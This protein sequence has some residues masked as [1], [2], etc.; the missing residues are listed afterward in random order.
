MQITEQNAGKDVFSKL[1]G[2]NNKKGFFGFQDKS[3]LL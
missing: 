1:S 3:E 2:G